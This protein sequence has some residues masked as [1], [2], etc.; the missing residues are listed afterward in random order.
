MNFIIKHEIKGRLRIHVVRSRMTYAEADTLCWFLEKQ[1]GITN[2]KVYERTAD[3]AI[4]YTGDREKLICI[5]RRFHFETAEI[6][7]Q[8][9]ASSGRTLNT[10]Y[11]EQLIEK[12]LLHYAGKLILPSPVRK[13]WLGWKAV[14]YI[15]KGI[16]CLARGKI[17][18]PV[19]DAT[20]ISVS[21]LRGDFNIA[22]SVM[23]LLGIGELLEEWTH[24]KSV[25]DLARSM[26][27]QVS[28]A[29]HLADRLVP[30]T[31][32][33]TGAV[34]LMTRNVTKALSVLMV[35]FS[36]ALKLAMP[37]AVLSAIRQAGQAGLTVKGGKYLEAVAEADTIVFDKTGTLTRAKPTVKAVVVFGDYPE[38]EALHIAACLEEHFPHSMARAVVEAAK[39]RKLYHEEMHSKVEYIVAHGIS[40]YIEEKRVIV[41]SRHFVFE[42]EKCR[43]RPEYQQRFEELPE[44]YSHL[45]LA[46]DGELAAV[47]CIEDPLR[48]E[49]KAVIQLL[50][51]AGIS[52][53]VMMTGDSE[54]TAA[55]IAQRV[56][57]DEYY[58]EVLPED[59]ADFIE[60]EKAAGRKVVMIGDGINDSPAL[61]ASD[62]GIAISGGAV[63]A[64]EIA[65]IMIEAEDLHEIVMLK[66]LSDAMM[67]RIHKNYKE[68]I[69]INSGLIVL[70]VAGW[71]QPTASALL[72]NMSTLTIS[73]NSMRS[74]LC[75][76]GHSLPKKSEK[77]FQ[78]Y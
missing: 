58:S 16:G 69:G 52:K 43:I 22:G 21:V 19:L 49:A 46:V 14:R 59:K 41:G 76:K 78:T 77:S 36:C 50:R 66:Y 6:P 39:K 42:D 10:F 40:S 9:L 38:S 3:A 61:S 63:L 34:W 28:K 7:E 26:S 25:G 13:L 53:I 68:I 75:D 29:E 48:E 15:G 37:I 1:E 70:G 45:Y 56:G 32:L 20:A 54:K 72:H 35:D 57:V 60:R 51:E 73:L 62:A 64:R 65:D 44:E 4:C 8:V 67:R 18:V 12:T 30:Y 2:V 24:K 47:I 5:L 11:R 23:F 33:G 27:V 55:S 71:I 31:L 17:E 74:L